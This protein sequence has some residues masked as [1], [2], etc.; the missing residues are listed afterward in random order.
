MSPSSPPLRT[1]HPVLPDYYP[2]A[3]SRQDIINALFDAGARHYDWIDRWMSFGT[4]RRYRREALQRHGVGPGLRVADV[5]TGTGVIALLAQEL[6]GPAGEVVAVDPSP[7]MLD[8]AR[9]AGVR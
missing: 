4:G 2:D 6:V 1:P 9:R 8:A 7:G 5:G 3:A